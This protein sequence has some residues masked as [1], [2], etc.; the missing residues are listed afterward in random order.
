M[1][2]IQSL[3]ADFALLRQLFPIHGLIHIGAG[4]GTILPT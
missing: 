1:N 2:I 3:S 4:A